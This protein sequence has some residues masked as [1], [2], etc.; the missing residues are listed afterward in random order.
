MLS[1][2]STASPTAAIEGTG[3]NTR[4]LAGRASGE[5]SVHTSKTWSWCLACNCLIA[6]L[7]SS[8]TADHDQISQKEYAE[9]TTFWSMKRATQF[10]ARRRTLSLFLA[11]DKNEACKSRTWIDNTPV[12][13]TEL[14]EVL[15]K[16]NPDSI[17]INVDADIAFASG[18]HAGEYKELIKQ[19][20]Q[21]WKSRLVAASQVGV[22]YVATMPKSRLGW[23]RKLQESAWAVISEG[24]SREAITPGVTSTEDLE[25]WF[26]EKLQYHNYSTW[27]HPSVTILPGGITPN[28]TMEM[29]PTTQQQTIQYG[30]L[31]HVDFGLTALG[32]NTDTQHLAYVLPPGDSEGDI[33]KGLLE[34][35]EKG[36]RLQDILKR[37]MRPGLTGNAVLANARKE[38][39]EAGIE[40]RIYSHPIGDWGHSAGALIGMTNMQDGVPVLG[41]LPLLKNMYYSIELFVEHYVPER[42]ET[43]VFPLEEDVYWDDDKESFEWVYGRQE[44]FHLIE[45]KTSPGLMVQG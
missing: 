38:M 25:W 1:E 32:L 43:L 10:S 16:C 7:S 19:L 27:F 41:D 31:L 30:D 45:A 14:R 8:V 12:L 5:H 9:D 34:G 21:P 13:W 26:R 6:F 17:V 2:A 15:E 3:E 42:N 39:H 36:N 18:L 11:D 40:G 20:D 44:R 29:A 33:P 23:Y 35:L 4:R 24:F 22:E 28:M 37:N